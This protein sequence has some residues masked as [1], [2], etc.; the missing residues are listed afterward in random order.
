MKLETWNLI[1][2]ALK[3]PIILYIVTVKAPEVRSLIESVPIFIALI[4]CLAAIVTDLEAADAT[5]ELQH[6][7]DM[8]KRKI[9]KN[10]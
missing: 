8:L 5:K 10:P 3:T 4:L 1:N 9:K 7:L 6:D 2:A